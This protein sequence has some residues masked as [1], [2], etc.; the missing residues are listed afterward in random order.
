RFGDVRL[1]VVDDLFELIGWD[2]PPFASF[3][4][5][6]HQLLPVKLL[7]AS[8][9]LDNHV[10]D[11]IDALVGRKAAPAPDALPPAADRVA[12][13]RLPRA[14]NL[15]FHVPPEWTSHRKSVVSGVSGQLSVASCQ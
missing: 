14:P 1:N 9:F 13:L 15:V 6:D 2:G 12:N 7:A 10:G 11:F 4:K 5:A 8:V 3:H